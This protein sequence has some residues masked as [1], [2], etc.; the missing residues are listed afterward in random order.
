MKIG[1]TGYGWPYLQ[2]IVITI[3]FSHIVVQFRSHSEREWVTEITS[4]LADE[5]TSLLK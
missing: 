4:S 3:K 2:E 1:L 5:M